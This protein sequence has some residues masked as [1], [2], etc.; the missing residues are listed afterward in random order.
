MSRGTHIAVDG[1][2]VLFGEHGELGSVDINPH[3]LVKVSLTAGPLLD[4]PCYSAPALSNGLL[5]LRNEQALAC[6]SLRAGG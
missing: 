3:E 5:Y 6:F 1:R 4:S 2:L